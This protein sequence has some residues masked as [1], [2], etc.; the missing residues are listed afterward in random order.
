MREKDVF[1]MHF[2]HFSLMYQLNTNDG[3]S[4]TVRIK[5]RNVFKVSNNAWD[6]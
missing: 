4:R 6:V 2:V 1:F 5:Q 3:K